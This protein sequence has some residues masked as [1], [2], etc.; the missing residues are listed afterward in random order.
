MNSGNLDKVRI[1]SVSIDKNGSSYR[2]RFTYP[3]GNRQEFRIAKATP[4]GWVTAIKAAQ[5]IN[6]DIDLGDLDET[7]ARYSPKHAKKLA[8]AKKI[9]TKEYNLKELWELY[10]NANKDRVAKT[11]Q[12]NSWK[13]FDH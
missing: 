8:I 4:E 2:I 5:L 6:R 12:N 1:G 13:Q 3:Q 11:T 9:E 7:Y 10:K